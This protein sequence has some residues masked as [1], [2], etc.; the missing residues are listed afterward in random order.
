MLTTRNQT[1]EYTDLYPFL[2]DSPRSTALFRVVL[3]EKCISL[4]H[5]PDAN[6]DEAEDAAS[7]KQRDQ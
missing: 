2:D 1:Q 7:G 6:R 5:D 3:P 4:V